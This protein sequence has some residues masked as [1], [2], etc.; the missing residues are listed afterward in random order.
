MIIKTEI[1]QKERKR[2]TEIGCVNRKKITI[3]EIERKYNREGD[4]QP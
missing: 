2:Q 1:V 3:G 4:G